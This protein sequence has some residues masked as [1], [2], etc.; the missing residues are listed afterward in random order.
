MKTMAVISK[1]SL[2]YKRMRDVKNDETFLKYAVLAQVVSLAV[3]TVPVSQHDAGHT[4]L[5]KSAAEIVV[6]L[7]QVKVFDL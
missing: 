2:S 6:R 3:W 4:G 5:L 1:S 7:H